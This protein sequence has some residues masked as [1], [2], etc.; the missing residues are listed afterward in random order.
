M[1][2]DIDATVRYAL[3]TQA[4]KANPNQ[5]AGGGRLLK[6]IIQELNLSLILI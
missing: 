3:D 2:L 6:M 5:L 1:K 4:Y